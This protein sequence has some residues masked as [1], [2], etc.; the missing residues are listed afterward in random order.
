[1]RRHIDDVTADDFSDHRAGDDEVEQVKTHHYP[2]G[3]EREDGLLAPA[4]GFD[5]ADGEHLVAASY[6]GTIYLVRPDLTVVRTLRA[7]QQKLG[8]GA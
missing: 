3:L 2:C 6:D 7:M 5:D 4:N 1:M 8:A